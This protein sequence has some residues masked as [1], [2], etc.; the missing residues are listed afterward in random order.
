MCAF[1]LGVKALTVDKLNAVKEFYK[2]RLFKNI[3]IYRCTVYT[4]KKWLVSVSVSAK[5]LLSK[6]FSVSAKTT[7]K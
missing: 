2:L 5:I 7:K 3:K 6:C 1:K 4:L